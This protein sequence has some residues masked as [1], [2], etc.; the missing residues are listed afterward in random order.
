MRK[1]D[2][3]VLAGGALTRHRRRTTLSLLGLAIGVAAVVILT[4]LGEG[5]R[6]FVRH[7]HAGRDGESRR[8]KSGE[9]E[10]LRQDLA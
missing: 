5:A 8:Y 1:V 10:E 6:D 2:V 3:L 9:L 7:E 4:A